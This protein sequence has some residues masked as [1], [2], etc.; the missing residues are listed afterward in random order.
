MP[1]LAGLT[2]IPCLMLLLSS[3]NLASAHGVGET[4]N[5]P[6]PLWLYLFGAAA[7][8]VVSFVLVAV[9][10]GESGGRS[11][12]P[13]F[14]LVRRRW[15]RATLASAPVRAALRLLSVALFVLA[16]VSGLVGTQN[17]GFNFAPTFIW[18]VWWVG[19]S[20]FTALVGNLWP[21]V[22]P[23]KVLFDTADSLARKFGATDGIEGSVPYPRRLGMWP[24]LAVYFGFVSL[25]VA[26]EGSP[27]PAILAL[28]VLVYSVVTWTG[29]GVFG[30]DTWLRRA[31]PFSLLFGVL[32]RFAPT[33]VR[34][35]DRGVCRDC[36]GDCAAPAEDCVNCYE[37]FAWAEP[38][39]RELALRPWAVGLLRPERPAADRL[40]FVV[41]MLAS[42][43]FDG[44][45]VTSVWSDTAWRIAGAFGAGPPGPAVHML[46]LFALTAAFF[47]IF[48]GA[49]AV[50]RRMAGGTRL[51]V[52][53]GTFAYSLV[54]IAL[55]YQFAHYYTLL[56]IGGQAI[57]PLLSDPFGWRWDLFGTASY[58]V[59]TGLVGAAFVWYSQIAA[60]ILGHAIAVYLAHLS[61]LRLFPSSRSVQRSQY[62]LLLVMVLY[63]VTSL[64]VL[65]QPIV[66]ERALV[67][68]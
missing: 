39:D 3:T 61:A 43:T 58:R 20:L 53:A 6:V 50:V 62:P 2:L 30:V 68:G 10:V 18:V 21:L 7:A 22:N 45:A 55:A 57:I 60:I 24:A 8:V 63:T 47:G 19:L 1:R 35:T 64:W 66:V 52:V 51:L 28:L 5:L 25:E 65:S 31:D 9:F 56:L 34:V 38:A 15:F 11:G 14:D 41:F 40:A 44:L 67:G 32:A 17:P 12:Y 26:F 42:V 54:P 16:V 59:N 48:L 23:W 49:I 33:E 29:M 37:C 27:Q 46:G 4:Y 36:S 13:R